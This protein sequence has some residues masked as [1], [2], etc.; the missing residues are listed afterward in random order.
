MQTFFFAVYI[1]EA[2][3]AFM[4]YSDNYKTKRNYWMTFSILF[5]LYILA[6]IANIIDGNSSYINGIVFFFIN[7]VFSKVC[8]EISIKSCVFH[9]SFLLAIMFLTEF[10]TEASA[11]YILHIP[12][13]AYKNSF[14]ALVIIGV[15]CKI[16]YLL[17]CKLVSYFFS[18]KNYPDSDNKRTSV[19]FLFPITMIITS[20]VLLYASTQYSF[21]RNLNLACTLISV[22][23]LIFCCFIFIYNQVIQ[24]QQS[25]LFNLRSEKQKEEINQTFYNLLEQKNA[26]QRVFVHDIKHHLNAINSIDSLEGV[27]KYVAKIEPSL[28]KYQFI[29]RTQNKMLDLI[30]SRYSNICAQNNIDFT[31]DVRVS[32]LNFIEDNDLAS[33]LGNLLDNAVEAAKNSLNPRIRFKKNN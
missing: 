33:M 11:S 28:D 30:L 20:F 26:E 9:S 14:N 8:F 31:A 4:Y 18:Y 27:R 21:S 19:L 24:R 2:I 32:N 7:I 5:G 16:L 15:I 10:V 3:I 22:I 1:F 12:I 13:D 17:I 29:G 25:E 6:F 23:S